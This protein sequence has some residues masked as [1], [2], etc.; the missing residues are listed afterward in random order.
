MNYL[1]VTMIYNTTV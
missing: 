1:Y